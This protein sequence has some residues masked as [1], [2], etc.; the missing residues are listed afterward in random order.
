[1]RSLY[2]FAA[3]CCVV[4][5]SGAHA[6][7][8]A[9]T[10]EDRYIAAR[11]AAIDQISKL[12]DVE[13]SDEGARKAEEAAR[14]EL[15]AQMK[16]ILAE[17][18]RKGFAP[19]ELNL[20]AFYRGDLGFGMLDGLRFDAET[21]RN[22]EKA[23]SGADGKYVQPRAHIIITTEHLFA[24]WLRAHKD[25]WSNGNVPQQPGAALKHESFYT[26]AIS[27]DAAVINF[28][29]LPIATPA[30]ATFAYGFLAG[31]T[32]DAIPDEAG[33]V[34]AS[35]RANGK[36]YIAYGSIDPKVQVPACSAMRAGYNKRAEL[37]DEKFRLKQIDRKAYDKLGDLRQQGEDAF[38]RCFTEQAPRQASFAAAVKQAQALLEVAMGR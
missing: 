5:L 37:A 9:A 17:P 32:Q 20:D 33:E 25:W 22:G 16:A 35:A 28:G 30:G 26:Q 23:G 19:P 4:T 13:K 36:V 14:G 27:T 24:R 38:R 12:Y 31:R 21:G 10:L 6:A 2:V 1:M 18:D 29:A 8:P 3:I 11:D 15:R 7:P 34:F